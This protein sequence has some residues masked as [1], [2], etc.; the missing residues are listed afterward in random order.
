M[1]RRSAGRSTDRVGKLNTTLSSNSM[2]RS[3]RVA[4]QVA[5]WS[6]SFTQ[7]LS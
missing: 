2:H 6:V 3:L 7:D 5:L 4:L 1:H